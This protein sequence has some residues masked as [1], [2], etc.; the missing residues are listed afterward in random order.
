MIEIKDTG[1]WNYNNSTYNE[2]HYLDTG[3]ADYLVELF[4]KDYTLFDFGCGAGY[5][6]KYIQEKGENV[7]T[8]GVEPYATNH[9]DLKIDN[10]VSKDLTEDFDLGLK[11]NLLCLEVLEHIPVELEGKAIDNIVRHCDNYLIISWA[12]IGQ[13]G[14]GHINCKAKE[15]VIALFE[16]RNYSYLDKESSEISK[17][18]KIGWL[19][20]NLCVFKKR[21]DK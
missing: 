20:T 16:S 2:N 12:H 18:A 8:L 9:A 19:K 11:G 7:N 4:G 10:I 3:A 14:H 6:L 1:A 13:N 17:S 15:D 21:Y 5:Y